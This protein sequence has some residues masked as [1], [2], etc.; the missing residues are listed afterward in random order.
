[1]LHVR[2]KLRTLELPE[3]NRS[4]LIS[5]LN[6]VARMHLRLGEKEVE[7][8]LANLDASPWRL[9][10]HLDT[11]A[12]ARHGMKRESWNNTVHRVRKAL[13]LTGARVRSGRRQSHLI[14][15][16][17][18]I[19][20]PLPLK[21]FKA[22]LGGFVSWCSE[23]GIAPNEVTQAVFERYEPVL[24]GSRMRKRARFTFLQTRRCWNHAADQF[25]QWPKVKLTAKL[26][27]DH[28]YA[29]PWGAFDQGFVEE[30]HRRNE[31]ILHPDPTDEG[32]RDAVEKVTAD[33]QRYKI[34]RLASALVAAT[35]RDPKSITGIAD[36][37]EI[38][39]AKA[40]LAFILARLRERDPKQQ[41]SMET[42]LLARFICTLARRWVGVPEEHL[43]KLQ[44]IARR[45]K[46]S[47][48]GM[49]PKNRR[50]LREF[51]DEELLARFLHL[52]QRLFDQAHRKKNLGRSDAIKLSVAFA[53][54]L[55]SVAPVRPKNAARIMFGRNLIQMGVGPGRRVHLHFPS[56]EVKN[57]VVL[58]FEVSGVTRELL[59][60]YVS[61]V[62][63]LLTDPN[64]Q[65]LFPGRGVRHRH[66]SYFSQQI[67]DLL[68][69]EIGV[70]VTAHQF[71]H[72]IGFIYLRENP[73]NYE[74]VRRLLGHKNINT[75][76]KFYAEMEMEIAA[77]SVDEVIN[78]R[79]DELAHLG[80][81]A[82][83]RR[84]R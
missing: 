66:E 56:E 11:I 60:A 43:T 36:L 28:R 26:N 76:I 5:A 62:R 48:S 29:L 21:P 8:A 15:E 38:Q 20:D 81:Q 72:L 80:R 4:D 84:R 12:Y 19:F 73:G 57:G 6:S 42:F 53:V 55:L 22:G 14:P 10:P 79:R 3:R 31:V 2:D 37:V 32:G 51:K 24:L 45:L 69:K 34:R 40:V 27:L 25:P 49:R 70:R 17:A 54:A 78:R 39:N 61:R 71:R 44:G 63:P 23:E 75:T 82:T 59:D 67:G 64:N 58:E 16:W 41:T 1:L 9:L 30:V 47:S 7:A 74:V 33:H 77:K 35:G 68:W 52:P 83:R 50:M 65:Y 18:V 13:Q 46:P